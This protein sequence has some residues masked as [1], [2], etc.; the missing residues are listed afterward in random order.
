M[1]RKVKATKK[2]NDHAS[3][4]SL[5]RRGSF[6]TS[7]SGKKNLLGENELVEAIASGRVDLDSIDKEA[8]PTTLQDM[9]PAEQQ[10]KIE[11]VAGK[12]SEL[13]K[14]INELSQKR[15]NHIAEQVEADGGA[16]D[17]LDHKLYEAVRAQASEAGLEYRD[18]PSY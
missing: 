16:D 15:D 1:E 6:N 3:V 2:L 10:A 5:A 17:S 13:A 11:E 4:T 8:L 7:A 14:A 18:G 9:A 12:R